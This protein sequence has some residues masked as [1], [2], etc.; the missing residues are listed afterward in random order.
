MSDLNIDS[1]LSPT[2]PTS[3][4]FLG[5]Y[6]TGDEYGILI[7][8]LMANTANQKVNFSF[9]SPASINIGGTLNVG[10][11]ILAFIM[12]VKTPFDGIDPTLSI[13]TQIDPDY[14]RETGSVD[15]SVQGN[16]LILPNKLDFNTIIQPK[17]YLNLGGSTQG[18][19]L[20]YMLYNN[21][22]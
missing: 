12:L 22:V 3:N 2:N 1:L 19:A 13:G 18:E 4:I 8:A 7:E 11:D 14:F 21:G 10:K 17:I 5:P 6:N 15:L 9:T 20:F 16:Y